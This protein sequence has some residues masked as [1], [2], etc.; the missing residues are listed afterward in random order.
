MDRAP[1]V[2]PTFR[3]DIE[4][5]PEVLITGFTGPG[6]AGLTAVDYL[7][8]RLEM[9]QIGH[10]RTENVAT[11]TPFEKG[12]PY[13]P[14][15]MFGHPD[16]DIAVLTS[17][18]FV[19]VPLAERFADALVD[20]ADAAG[21]DEIATLSGIPIPHGP[22][23]HRTFFVATDDYRERRLPEG[24][25]TPMGTGLT[26]G[27][28]AAL[29]S[30][31]LDSPPAVGVFVTPVHAQSPD[32]EAALRLV[33]TVSTVYDLDVDLEP[34]EAFADEIEHYY[35]DLA[36]RIEQAREPDLPD[37]RMYM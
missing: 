6:L 10:L 9:E 14:I 37:D 29:L 19:P 2:T 21:F 4:T 5:S 25:V 8:E 22:E 23:D 36:E 27:V 31:G 34:L 33:E 15:R 26:D 30:R 32:V 3:L 35:R 16:R 1:G 7:V 28:N 24:L 11:I 17:A 13:H 12:R 20:P 18:L